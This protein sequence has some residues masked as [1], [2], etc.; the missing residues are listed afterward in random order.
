VGI[1]GL[2]Q[3]SWSFDILIT[4]EIIKGTSSCKA[5]TRCGTGTENLKNNNQ[6]RYCVYKI[7]KNTAP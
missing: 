5:H 2:R 7:M 4:G 1:N 3:E 6:F